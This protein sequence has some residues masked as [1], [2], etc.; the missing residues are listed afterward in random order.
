MPHLLSQLIARRTQTNTH[1][2]VAATAGRGI[3]AAVTDRGYS[4]IAR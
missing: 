1:F 2:F 4:V 3:T